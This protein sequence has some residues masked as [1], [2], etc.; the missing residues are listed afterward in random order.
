MNTEKSG[1]VF[2]LQETEPK[3]LLGCLRSTPS[4][5]ELGW[6]HGSFFDE[7]GSMSFADVGNKT[8]LV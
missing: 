6:I 3:R 7:P 4:D 5:T 2:L 8:E 1:G